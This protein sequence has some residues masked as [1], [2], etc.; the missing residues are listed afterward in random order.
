MHYLEMLP[1]NILVFFKYCSPWW[2]RIK[3]LFLDCLCDSLWSNF[4]W[5]KPRMH[6]K[7]L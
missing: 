3:K 1:E 6:G 2:S 7:L 4:R 5:N